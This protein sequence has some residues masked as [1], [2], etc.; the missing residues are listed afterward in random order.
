[1]DRVASAGAKVSY[2]KDV[3]FRRWEGLPDDPEDEVEAGDLES[4]AALL[5]GEVD[6]DYI[7]C[8]GPGR[9]S[10]DRSCIV[11]VD[12]P[13]HLF[14]YSCEGSL[15]AAYASL[16]RRLK[17]APAPRSTHNGSFALRLLGETV[18][19]PTTLVETYLRMRGL[20]VRFRTACASMASA[21]TNRLAAIVQLCWPKGARLM[22][23]SSLYIE[24]TCG[25][26]A[27]AKPM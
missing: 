13:S 9:P 15:P 11:R 17:L 3:Q 12:G 1:M 24:P 23:P 20:T 7:C 10:D 2:W 6:G 4:Y 18:P 27:A 19:A 8:P 14:I 26:M 25:V 16:R 22:A 5:G 21:C